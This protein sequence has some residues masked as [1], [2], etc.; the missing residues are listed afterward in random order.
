[1]IVNFTSYWITKDSIKLYNALV[2]F[3]GSASWS[4]NVAACTHL[5][6]FFVTQCASVK[7]VLMLPL[8]WILQVCS[9]DVDAEIMKNEFQKM[10]Q[11]LAHGAAA[12]QP[13]L[14]LTV[15]VVQVCFLALNMLRCSLILFEK[16]SFTMCC[17]L[18]FNVHIS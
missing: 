6:T 16:Y 2:P 17:F 8:H 1:M 9:S 4:L 7:S 18:M 14:P 13:P 5:N 11:C 15:I 10:V 12:C 3:F